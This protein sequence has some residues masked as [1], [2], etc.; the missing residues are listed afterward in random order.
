MSEKA[1]SFISKARRSNFK[2]HVATMPNGDVI[3][4]DDKLEFRKLLHEYLETNKPKKVKLV[5][6]VE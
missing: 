5:E 4:S 2:K 3:A 1:D 6:V